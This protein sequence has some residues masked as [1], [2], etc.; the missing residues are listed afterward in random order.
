[1][2]RRSYPG[3]SG[4][5]TVS[6]E[7]AEIL[8]N[9]RRRGII[10]ALSSDPGMLDSFIGLF[11]EPDPQDS[12]PVDKKDVVN[13]VAAW[14]EGKPVEKVP[15]GKLKS[16]Q[17]T[18]HQ[19]HFPA[20]DEEDIINHYPDEGLVEPLPTVDD[21]A[22]MVE[23][24]PYK[25]SPFPG[26]DIPWDADYALTTDEA[27]DILSN[28]RRRYTLRYLGNQ[29]EEDFTLGELSE[30]VAEREKSPDEG[31]IGSRERKT[32]YIGLSQCHL[33]QMD[34]AEV[35][36]YDDNRKTIERGEY[37]DDVAAY[38]PDESEDFS[39]DE[40]NRVRALS[41]IPLF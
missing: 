25:E 5:E 38:L 37:F 30:H 36:E 8:R 23:D 39:G 32:A 6:R 1:M 28:D 29:S 3:I 13:Q 7:E 15:H 21:Y 22:E 19:H 33:P 17:A 12:E 24:R 35:I 31:P 26:A 11:L 9:S 10:R 2:S 4:S 20:L 27:Y 41:V 40:G 14:E 34:N 18:S 16:V